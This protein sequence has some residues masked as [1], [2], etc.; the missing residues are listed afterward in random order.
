MFRLMRDIA[1]AL[2]DILYPPVC[3]GCGK[4]YNCIDSNLCEACW[5]NLWRLEPPLCICCGAPV[6]LNHQSSRCPECLD[7]PV[8]YDAARSVVSYYDPVIHNCIHDLKYRFHSKL[9][10]DLGEMIQKEFESFC[11]DKELDAIVPVPLHKQRLRYREFNQSALLARKLSQSIGVPI[12]EDIVWRVKK[13]KPQSQLNAE[14]RKINPAGAFKL[15]S[16]ASVQKQ[17]LAVIDDIYTTG[18]TINE[19][20]ATLRRGGADY[21]LVITL[22]RAVDPRPSPVFAGHSMV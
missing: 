2:I 17:R 1:T 20:C 19:V 15:A 18:S 11:R 21:I 10:N 22:A 13:T 16:P 7:G 9:A 14:Q 3:S 12:R 4:E 6:N 5:K 8:Y